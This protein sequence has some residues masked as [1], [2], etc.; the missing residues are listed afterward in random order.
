MEMA[1]KALFGDI[2]VHQ[3]GDAFHVRRGKEHGRE[4]QAQRPVQRDA[5]DPASGPW[6]SVGLRGGVRH[7]SHRNQ[8][9]RNVG[10]QLTLP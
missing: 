4:H 1:F 3:R 8:A 10:R 5:P 6:S 7:G 9:S 2:D